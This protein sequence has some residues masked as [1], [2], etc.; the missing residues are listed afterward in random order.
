LPFRLMVI[1]GLMFYGD[2]DFKNWKAK[3]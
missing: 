2:W 1:L 3:V